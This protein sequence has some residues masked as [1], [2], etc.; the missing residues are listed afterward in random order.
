M[1]LATLNDGSRDGMLAVVSEDRKRYTSAGG[2]AGTLQAALDDWKNVGP[3]LREL[4]VRLDIGQVDGR[5]FDPMQCLAPLPRAYQF[6]DASAYVNH[7]ELVR[8]GRGAEMPASYWTDPLIYQ[9]SSDSFL[10]P[11]APIRMPAEALDL[12]SGFGLD[13]EAEVAVITDDVPMGVSADEALS[14][15]KF[16]ALLNDITLRHLVP[17]EVAKGFGFFQSKPPSSFAPLVVTPDALG[18]AWHDGKLNGRLLVSV[19]TRL[20]GDLDSGLDMTFD[21]GQLIAH[22]ARTRP[23]SAGTIIGSGTVSNRDKD[24]GSAR[25]ISWGGKGYAC[26]AEMRMMETVSHGHPDTRFLTEGDVVRIELKDAQE[27]SV[28]GLIEQ[29]VQ[30]A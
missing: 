10:A 6:A 25:P 21:F 7:M 12:D 23:L 29:R 20:F 26:I 28:F 22:A 19:N 2:V 24:G 5:P 17:G 16:L 18:P 27:R 30:R 9:G 4:S 13:F 8:R 11:H 1:R 15:I 14:H 3:R